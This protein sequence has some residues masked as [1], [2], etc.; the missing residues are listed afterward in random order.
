MLI[1]IKKVANL[2]NKYKTWITIEEENLILNLKLLL[3][4]NRLIICNFI[5]SISIVC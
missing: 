1:K 3:L 2:Q 4:L 5:I